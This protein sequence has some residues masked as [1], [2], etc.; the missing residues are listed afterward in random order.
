MTLLKNMILFLNLILYLNIV[1]ASENWERVKL[2]ITNLSTYYIAVES[3]D[4]DF[5]GDMDLFA[6]N[7]KGYIQ[8][9]ENIGTPR[10]YRFKLV[11]NGL[12]KRNSFFS[13]QGY[14]KVIPRFIDI[15]NDKDFDL[16]IGNNNG[17]ISFYR[18]DGDINTP[19]FTLVNSGKDKKSSYFNINVGLSAAPFF[20]DIDN[21]GDYDLFIGN[22]EGYIAYYRNDGTPE[23]PLFSL[24]YGGWS[25][26]DSFFQID[27]GEYSIPVFRDIDNNDT[28]DFFIGN[29]EGEI[30]YYKNIGTPE[31]Y[32]F[33]LVSTKFA[34]IKTS[35]DTTL[36]F[37][38]INN[39]GKDELFVGNNEGKILLFRQNKSKEVISFDE[40]SK[41]RKIDKKKKVLASNK[42]SVI[43]DNKDRKEHI[44]LMKKI[45]SEISNNNFI[46]ALNLIN[47][48]EK[49]SDDNEDIIKLKR[50]CE[51]NIKELIYKLEKNSILFKEVESDFKKGIKNYVNSHYKKSLYYFKKVLSIDP[52]N[53]IALFYKKRSEKKLRNV[54]N[55]KKALSKF[56]IAVAEYNKKNYKKAFLLISEVRDLAPDNIKYQI[57]FTTY[58]NKWYNVEKEKYYNDNMEIVKKMIIDKNY[59]SALNILKELNKRFPDDIEVKKLIQLCEKKSKK[60]K[61]KYNKKMKKK[62]I[63]KGDLCFKKNDFEEAL[64]YYKIALKY[65]PEDYKIKEKIK[66]TKMKLEKKKK[67]VLSPEDVKFHLQEGMRFYSMGQYKKAIEEWKKVLEIDPDN[68]MAKKNIEKARKKLKE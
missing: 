56:K 45:N 68:I 57:T 52:A 46:E 25:K 27:V 19:H 33:R 53:K 61:I 49:I 4:I 3:V 66:I 41:K 65:S 44:F 9:Y 14:K 20:V 5:D 8:F 48:I 35:G 24:V 1:Y 39:D 13:I 21:D 60:V 6:G 31:R 15:D 26:K 42:S 28:F 30:Y 62:Y 64:K 54:L 37:S 63:E 55:E 18:N 67:R 58:S 22:A 17:C 12:N 40:Y 36:S 51:D 7:W 38:D 29:F 16:F 59:I 32:N 47:K 11:K 10:Y 50:E 23:S 34:N 43:K 2:E